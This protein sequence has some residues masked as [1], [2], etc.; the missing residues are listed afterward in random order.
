MWVPG[1]FDGQDRPISERFLFG[2][3]FVV[4]LAQDLLRVVA[5]VRRPSESVYRHRITRERVPQAVLQPFDSGNLAGADYLNVD[6]VL[7]GADNRSPGFCVRRQPRN[8]VFR[9]LLIHLALAGLA[10]VLAMFGWKVNQTAVQLDV[11][12]VHSGN[13]LASEST[14]GVQA[15]ERNKLGTEG[16]KECCHLFRT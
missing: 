8:E 5:A 13:L 2:N 9:D 16:T 3:D 1:I 12:P 15:E 11:R 14:E 7:F 4:I 6:P 10:T